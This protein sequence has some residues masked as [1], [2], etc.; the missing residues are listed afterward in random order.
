MAMN[1]D[2]GM[3]DPAEEVVKKAIG[4]AYQK[5]KQGAERTRQ[6]LE[7]SVDPDDYEQPEEY[8]ENEVK[9]AAGETARTVGSGIQDSFDSARKEVSGKKG[10]KVRG[11]SGIKEYHGDIKEAGGS[12]KAWAGKDAA[13][14]QSVGATKETG[15][16]SAFS[17]GAG[18]SAGAEVTKQA[19]KM[20]LIKA[21]RNELYREFGIHKTSLLHQMES[22]L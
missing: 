16:A 17:S 4:E 15:K 8:A 14:V 2:I 22:I 21:K 1:G 13:K 5:A 18:A 20:E 3:F 7:Q 12:V 9:E 10:I 6:E 11:E 19:A